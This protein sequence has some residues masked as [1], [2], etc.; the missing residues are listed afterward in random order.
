MVN[1]LKLG[2]PILQV[3]VQLFWSSVLSYDIMSEIIDYY[4]TKY[5]LSTHKLA[6]E[7][8]QIECSRCIC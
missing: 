7:Q 5:R 2:C 3:F 6:I 8:I 4:L 1:I